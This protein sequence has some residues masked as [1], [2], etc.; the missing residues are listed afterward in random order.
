MDWSVWYTYFIRR[1]RGDTH[2][3]DEPEVRDTHGAGSEEHLEVLWQLRPAGIARVH[4]DEVANCG[5]HGNDL[6]HEVKCWSLLLDP[7]LDALHLDGDDGEH[8]H[9][10]PVEL[11]EA[12]PGAC[13][14][15]T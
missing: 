14:V 8:L 1:Q 2:L 5:A 9:S 3:A 4:G 10:D 11:V 7:V 6:S 15:I 13:K 12:P